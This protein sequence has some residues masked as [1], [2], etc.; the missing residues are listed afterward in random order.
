[1]KDEIYQGLSASLDGHP[2]PDWFLGQAD[3][4]PVGRSVQKTKF[5]GLWGLLFGKT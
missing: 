5:L 4:F 3:R 1:M 2:L